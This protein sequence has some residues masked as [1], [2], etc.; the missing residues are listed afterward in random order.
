MGKTMRYFKIVCLLMCFVSLLSG[1]QSSP[2]ASTDQITDFTQLTTQRVGVQSGALYELSLLEVCPDVEIAYFT[3]ATDMYV[4]LE[5]G[6]I[7]AFLVE[8]ISYQLRRKTFPWL[9]LLD[10]TVLST[11][12]GIA[13]GNH[14]RKDLLHQQLEEFLK[15]SQSNGV[16][17][18]ME[19]YWFAGFDPNQS[20]VDKS[21]ITG[22]NGII[23]VA[24]ENGYEPFSYIGHGELQGYDI[25]MIYRF[26]RE[27]GYTPEFYSIEYDA[28][29]VGLSTGKF[30]MG[31]GV[32]ISE[33]RSENMEF[34]RAYVHLGISV[35]VKGSEAEGTGFFASLAK[36]FHQ[37]FIKEDRWKLFLEGSGTTLLITALSAIFGTALGFAIYLICKNGNRTVN[38]ING[39]ISWLIGGT[40]TVL[41][42]MILYYLVF[43]GKMDIGG[44]WV[45]IVGFTL[46]FGYSIYAILEATVSAIGKGQDEG[47]RAL[48][49]SANQTFVFVLLP[50]ALRIAFPQIKSEMVNLIKETS[51]VGY[52]SI[53]DLTRM[54]DIVRGRT[55]EAFFPLITTAMIYFLLIWLI[56]VAV[57]RIEFR[58]TDREKAIER[59]KKGIEVN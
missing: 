12:I 40:P 46:L 2:E 28:I 5:Q 42:L 7:D 30:D 51:V 23:T 54:S 36:S 25:D 56:I 32:I 43:V 13:I 39:F 47:A 3:A 29:P 58:V 16:S 20:I 45:A 53:A 35:A 18:E 49:Y 44:V 50:Q 37:T 11:P 19:A 1:C 22:E 9:K 55:Y 21:G 31:T 57:K 17:A 48:G 8:D 15:S 24:V 6:K 4:A 27:Y 59:I 10:G 14:D 41:L 26:C 38:Q 33:E 52:I 34:T